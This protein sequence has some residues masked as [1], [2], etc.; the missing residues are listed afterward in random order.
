MWFAFALLAQA[1]VQCAIT[2]TIV[3]ASYYTQHLGR[4]IAPKVVIMGM[5]SDY[6]DTYVVL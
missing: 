6:L 4:K 2:P 3:T 5:V 1:L